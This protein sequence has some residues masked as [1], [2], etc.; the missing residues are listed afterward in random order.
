MT[1]GYCCI[2]YWLASS[3]HRLRPRAF[4]PFFLPSVFGGLLYF[5]RWGVVYP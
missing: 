3:R 5:P 2:T 4:F 1:G